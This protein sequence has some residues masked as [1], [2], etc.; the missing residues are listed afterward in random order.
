MEMYRVRF[1]NGGSTEELQRAISPGRALFRRTQ[2]SCRFPQVWDG[3][4][5][6]DQLLQR[7]VSNM[8]AELLCA[9]PQRL[10]VRSS[11]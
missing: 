10:R 3:P 9:P 2:A 7:E 8:L 1:Q 5:P 6:P 11:Q 4:P